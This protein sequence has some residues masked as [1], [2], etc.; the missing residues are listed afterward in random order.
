MRGIMPQLRCPACSKLLSIPDRLAGK[1][2]QC[3]GCKGRIK[4][5][6]KS[7]EADEEIF[8]DFEE[9]EEEEEE[10]EQ[11]R[12]AGEK[13][14]RRIVAK[15]GAGRADEEEEEDEGEDERITSRRSRDEDKPGRRGRSRDEDEDDRPSRR[16]SRDDD[17]DEDDR[18]SRRRSR[19]GDDAISRRITKPAPRRRRM[20]RRRD[21]EP[22]LTPQM[23]IGGGIALGVMLLCLIAPVI[24][25]PAVMLPACLGLALYVGGQIWFIIVAFKDDVMQGLL[26]WFIPFYFLYYLLVNWDEEKWPF[27]TSLAGIAMMMLG[28]CAA[29]LGG[30]LWH[31]AVN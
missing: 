29:S 10:E 7:E 21:D 17:E 5:P 13:S 20:R 30:A 19:D 8:D 1:M 9:T 4:V 27:F 2:G 26:C 12:R 14:D 24:F 3:P 18:P 16:R 22:W 15:R 23:K 11:P 6:A 31:S 28:G 25:P